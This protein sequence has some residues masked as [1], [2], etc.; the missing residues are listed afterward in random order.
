[1]QR[2]RDGSLLTAECRWTR[3][4]DEHTQLPSV[5]AI[6]TD[7]SQRKAAAREIEQLAF[8]DQ[9]TGLPNRQ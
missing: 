6:H 7:V 3:V 1:M 8:Y 5:L 4:T 9:L 2:R